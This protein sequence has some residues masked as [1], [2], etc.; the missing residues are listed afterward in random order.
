MIDLTTRYMGL[1]LRNPLVVSACPLGED[2]VTIMEMERAGAAAVVLPSL[3][4]EQLV[5]ESEALSHHLSA[6]TESFAEALHFLP[7]M[8]DY[9]FG[10][11]GYLEH[12]R[13]AT[14]TVDIPIIASLNGV[15]PGGW[16]RYA[17]EMEQAGADA[18][19]LNIYHLPT[20]A[21][22][23][24]A[25]VEQGYLD[26]VR[27]VR[28]AVMIPLAV[29]IAP[30]FSALPNMARRLEQA[31]ADGLVLFNRFYQADFDLNR[32]E[33]RPSLALSTPEEL[34]LRLHW[35]AIL[36]GHVGCDLAITGGVHSA[37]DVLKS[38]M[39]GAR[40]AMMTSALL[41]RG[42]GYLTE[43]LRGVREWLEEN[44]YESIRQM[45]GSMSLRSVSDPQAFERTNYLKV[46]SSYTFRTRDREPSE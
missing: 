28:S 36:F 34:R 6:G 25:E 21:K 40:V 15:S 42:V 4:E 13:Q 45:Q 22:V 43:V 30:F 19:E 9:N 24:A 23:T 39:A 12:I 41:Q 11:D 29:K 10:P 16:L 46:L 27:Q 38:M 5:L 8:A 33:V 35:T 44:E 1:A 37:T 20:S 14:S 32:L 17:K 7:E 26:L 31:G 3:F 2:L 18:L